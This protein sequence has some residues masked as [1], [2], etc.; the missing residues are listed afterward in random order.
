MRAVILLGLNFARAQWIAVAVML[1][2]LLGIAQVFR[3]HAHPSDVLFF[4]RWHAGYAL[5][6]SMGLTA[7]VLQVERKSRRILAVLSKG[8]H[9][10]QLLGWFLCGSTIIAAVFSGLIGAIAGWLCRETGAPSDALIPVTLALFCCS[11]AAAA[12][13]LLFAVFL[14]PFLATLASSVVLSLPLFLEPLGYSPGWRI[15]P[16]AW[17][18]HFLLSFKFLPTGK[19]IWEISAAALCQIVVFWM[20]AAAIFSR[21]DVTISPE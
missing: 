13:G 10:W 16:A 4:L 18:I 8:I 17:M 3:M 20:I 1:A 5:F 19:E 6:L 12:T 15:F 14:H 2:Y 7:P 21:R 11:V 9:R